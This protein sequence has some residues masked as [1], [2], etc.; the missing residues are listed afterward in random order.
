MK[1]GVNTLFLVPGDV[2]GSETYLRETLRAAI[3]LYPEV[4]FVLFTNLENNSL[5]RKLFAENSNVQ[6]ISLFCKAAIRP[7]RILLE[8]TMLPIAVRT[9]KIDI[10]WSPGYTAPFYCSTPQ[11]VTIHDLQY[12]SFPED[13]NWFERTALD[14][15]VRG[16]CRYCDAVI[17]VSQFSRQEILKHGFA[18]MEKTH[19]HLEGVDPSFGYAIH[20]SE[21]EYCLEKLDVKRPYIL[22]VAHS[23]PHKKLDLLVEA[24]ATLE[25]KIPHNLV[26]VGR[27]RRGEK[28]IEIALKRLENKGRYA[29]FKDGLPF[30]ALQILYRAAGIFVLPSAYEGFGLPVLEAMLS[31]AIVL[32]TNNGALLEVG[33]KHA[34]RIDPI[35]TENIAEQILKVLELPEE[36]KAQRV[37]LAKKWAE[38]F[39]WQQTA[40][41]MFTD[42]F[43]ILTRSRTKRG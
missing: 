37:K 43:T 2:G 23:Y 33:Q 11:V 3:S 7:L 38:S 14:F 26:I 20:E 21:I 28:Q 32:T 42:F 8:Q 16:A 30:R 34:F 6:F 10:L 24:F 40:N 39:T 31:G 29:R 13:M 27:P 41:E 9:Q 4:D 19:A 12:K 25:H 15:L 5:L 35:N 1:I 18:S 17:A 22:S 36:E